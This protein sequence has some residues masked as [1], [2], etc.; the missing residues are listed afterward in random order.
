MRRRRVV[1]II[2]SIAGF[3]LL[4]WLI[5]KTGIE[6]VRDGL[7]TVG[8]GFGVILA[9][10]FTRFV[11]RSY[12][13]MLLLEHPAPLRAAVAATISGDALGNVTPLGLAAS[14]P[15]KSVYLTAHAPATHSFAALTAENFFYS[16]SVAI[17]ICIGGVALL[18]AFTLSP[19]VRIY[20]CISLAAMGLVLGTAAWIALRKPAAASA[21]IARVPSRRVAGLLE[22]VQQLEARAYG[23]VARHDAP[24][25]RVVLVEAVFHL[26]SLAECWYTLWLLTG[27]SQLLAALAFDSVNRVINVAFRVIPFRWGVDQAAASAVADSVGVRPDVAIVLALVRTSRLIVW[28]AVGFVIWARNGARKDGSRLGA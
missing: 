20:G 1:S 6:K 12:A 2:L 4:A 28:A 21:L 26:V 8:W 3:V 19:A 18:S 13:W 24:I 10:S 15:A 17:Y 9:L 25:G 11:L 23:A 22:R 27:A 7:L 5:R 14:E 16:V